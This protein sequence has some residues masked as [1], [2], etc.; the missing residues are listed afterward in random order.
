[1]ASFTISSEIHPTQSP[2]QDLFN[3]LGDF[4]NFKDILPEDKVEG[5]EYSGEK[6]AF[7]IKGITRL[8]IRIIKKEPFSSITFQTEGLA[9]FNFILE[10]KFIGEASQK[11]QCAVEMRGDMN[12][13]I[14]SMAEK[15][16][17]QLVNTMSFKLSK[18]T[19]EQNF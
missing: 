10:A 5:F 12:P 2:L 14:L 19:L 18:L 6:A 16:L 9:R 13:F 3:Y 11:G 4:K 1:M 17:A 15:P 8:E 7:T